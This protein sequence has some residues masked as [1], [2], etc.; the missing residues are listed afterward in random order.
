VRLDQIAISPEFSP[1]G[2]K[3]VEA[4]YP[5]PLTPV[6]DLPPVTVITAATVADGKWIVRG[7]TVDNG[8]VESV[9]VNGRTARAVRENFAEWEVTLDDLKGGRRVTLTAGG[10][11]EAGNAEKTPHVMTVAVP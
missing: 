3:P 11:D 9:T 6:D 5:R 1:T 10:V 4:Q 8:A 2:V 7:T